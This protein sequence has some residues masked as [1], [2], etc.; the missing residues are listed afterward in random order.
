MA[1]AHSSCF[2]S[3]G[4]NRVTRVSYVDPYITNSL[5]F[6]TL[7]PT[8]AKIKLINMLSESGL[9]VIEATS[10]VSPKWVPQV[11]MHTHTQC[12][13]I[14]LRAIHKLHDFFL[15]LLTGFCHPNVR[16]Q[17]RWRWWRVSAGSPGW[18][19]KSSPPISR[20]SRL[21][22]VS[23]IQSHQPSLH[24]HPPSPSSHTIVVASV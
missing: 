12:W 11:S 20:V 16:W 18:L 21:L 8:E 1:Q 9:S 2:A 22:W 7:V 17:T 19:I 13:H 24:K 4:D 5:H 14:R 23:S 15:S 3:P 10:F 6:Q